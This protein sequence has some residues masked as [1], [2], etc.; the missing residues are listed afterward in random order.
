MINVPKTKCT[1]YVEEKIECATIGRNEE[2]R[3]TYYIPGSHLNKVPKNET[4]SSANGKQGPTTFLFFLPTAE[5]KQG[6][7]C[8]FHL[9]R[10]RPRLKASRT[11]P[12]L[13]P[14]TAGSCSAKKMCCGKPHVPFVECWMK[15]PFQP[16]QCSSSYP[17]TDRYSTAVRYAAAVLLVQQ[18]NSMLV[19]LR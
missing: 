2:Q 13:P 15:Q 12:C 16:K 3:R 1:T 6:P 18:Y 19:V 17:G 10:S 5:T 4:S 14:A 7:E 9:R 8:L 11:P